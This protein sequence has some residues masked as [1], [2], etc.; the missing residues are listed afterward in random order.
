M[1]KCEIYVI[2]NKIPLTFKEADYLWKY[3]ISA[4]GTHLGLIMPILNII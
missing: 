2:C 3:G 1:S 4:L